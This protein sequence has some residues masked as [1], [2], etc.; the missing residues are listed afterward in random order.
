MTADG[1]SGN[2]TSVS[3]ATDTDTSTSTP[4]QYP[5]GAYNDGSQGTLDPTATPPIPLSPS[6]ATDSSGRSTSVDTSSL[7]TFAD[8]LDTL[9]DM[10]GGAKTRVDNIPDLAPGGA[11][12]K[13]A[14]ELKKAVTG[15]EG[16]RPNFSKALHD[17]RTSL[18]DTADSMRALAAKYTSM[19]DLNQ[20]AGTALNDLVQQAGSDLKT[21]SS[22]KI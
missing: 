9:A 5:G 6:R 11:D 15:D 13:E 14:Q 3:P 19:E 21:L 7:K 20:K 1:S 16:L 12:F 2:G 4:D 18:M 8:N 10:V 22:D 17:V